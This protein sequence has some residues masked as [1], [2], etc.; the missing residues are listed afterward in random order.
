MLL[1][2]HSTLLIGVDS[3]CSA[4]ATNNYQTQ[5]IGKFK[6]VPNTFLQEITQ[7]LLHFILDK[8]LTRTIQVNLIKYRI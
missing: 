8:L 5:Q 1:H 4:K 3:Y 6:K 7:L 2:L